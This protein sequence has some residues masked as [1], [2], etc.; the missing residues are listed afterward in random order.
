MAPLL[1]LCRSHSLVIGSAADALLTFPFPLLVFD[2]EGGGVIEP[3]LLYEDK[4]RDRD[5][6]RERDESALRPRF[7]PVR[8]S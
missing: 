4:D 1:T 2:E 7:L 3:D 8:E 5:R 6:D